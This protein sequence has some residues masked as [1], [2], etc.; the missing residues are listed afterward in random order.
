MA[1]TTHEVLVDL[2]RSDPDIIFKLV[3]P[4]ELPKFTTY[5][6]EMSDLTEK[7]TAHFRADLVITL[8]KHNRVVF[9]IV[10]EV[11]LRIDGDK[12]YSWPCYVT[13]TRARWRANACVV[14]IC[15]DASV[16]R[17]AAEPILL[18]SGSNVRILVIGPDKIPYV[19]DPDVARKCPSLAILSAL[20]HK[21]EPNVLEVVA[22][23][24][25][26]ASMVDSE[27]GSI[28]ADL[29]MMGLSSSMTKALEEMM[30]KG[31]Y[32]YQSEWARGYFDKG[33]AEGV[34][35]GIEKG[36]EKGR[37]EGLARALLS[38]LRLRRISVTTDQQRQVVECTDI[39][40]LDR[41]LEAAM[42]AT[43]AD[44]V[45]VA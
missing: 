2:F 8:K 15:P 31:K 10:L 13:L 36:I 11:Q 24:L 16:A 26:A 29:L 17:W 12:R 21:Y 30:G 44:D 34:E 33:V 27:N 43:S 25:L 35:K 5:T 38:A 7:A 18:G 40:K 3:D 9:I 14:A 19:T 41:W 42:T 1:S 23:G 45:F 4:A 6:V 39:E 28:Y 22:N 32:E 37:A 20:A